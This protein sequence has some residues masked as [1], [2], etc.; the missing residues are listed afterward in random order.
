[1]D[2]FFDD[3]EINITSRFTSRADFHAEHDEEAED[4]EVMID[5]KVQ[6]GE[7]TY[8]GISFDS[9]QDVAGCQAVLL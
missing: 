4:V 9:D 3:L 6:V 1:L 5:A 7:E 8:T 2:S